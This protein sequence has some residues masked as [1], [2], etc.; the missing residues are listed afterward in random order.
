MRHKWAIKLPTMPD[1]SKVETGLSPRY[2]DW[3]RDRDTHWE[4]SLAP[5][6]ASLKQ[7]QGCVR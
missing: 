2:D 4:V 3:L 5:M 1:G 7:S 6:T